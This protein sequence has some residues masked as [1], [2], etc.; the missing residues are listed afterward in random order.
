MAEK[1]VKRANLN[2]VNL[3][4]ADFCQKMKTFSANQDL[5]ELAGLLGCG[6]PT[7][8][9][10]LEAL[11]QNLHHDL[12]AEYDA[13]LFKVGL[14]KV[15][16][17]RVGDVLSGRVNNVTHFGAFVDIGLGVNGLIHTTKMRGEEK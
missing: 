8:N 15:E 1:I 16:N 4:K 14:T 6:L 11:Q 10:I 9:M 2:L 7:L 13:P 12:R 17:L 5:E 3:G